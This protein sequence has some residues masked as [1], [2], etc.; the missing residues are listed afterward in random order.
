M[1][2]AT[3]M[4]QC[5]V[6]VNIKV[7]RIS[8]AASLANDNGEI[9]SDLFVYGKDQNHWKC[10]SRSKSKITGKKWSRYKIKDQ[11][12]DLRSWSKIITNT[13]ITALVDK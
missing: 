6:Q 5:V 2:N 1:L 8:L 13:D 7:K 11:K 4:L 9:W 10:D 3:Q 12:C